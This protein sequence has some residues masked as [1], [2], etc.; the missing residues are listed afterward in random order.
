[1]RGL[2][3][4]RECKG[5]S[6]V[7][8][9]CGFQFL[10]L[11]TIISL[12][13][14]TA[15]FS[16]AKKGTVDFNIPSLDL[17]QA[18]N[19]FARQAKVE[20]V[21]AER[22][23]DGVRTR[24]VVGAFQRERALELLLAGTGLRVGF[25]SGDS[26]IVQRADASETPEVTTGLAVGAFDSGTMLLAQAAVDTSEGSDGLA[27]NVG[28]TRHS[29]D[30]AT[31]GQ[32]D[33][34]FDEIVITGTSIRG[35]VP[36]S[37]P[38]EI[39]DINAIRN[40]GAGTA[41]EFISTL[42]Q[43]S[44]TLTVVG[45]AGASDD[46]K[47]VRQDNAADLRGLGVGTTLVLLNGR[48]MAPSAGGRTAD[49]SFI[50]LGAVERVEVLTDGASAVYGADAVGGV[51]NFVL[52]DQQ[53]GAETS[54]GVGAVDGGRETLNVDQSFGFNW[55]DGNAFLTLG[56]MDQNSLSASDRSYSKA[57]APRILTGEERRTNVLG[58]IAQHLGGDISISGDL[59]HSTRAIA[60]SGLT[61]TPGQF[62]E[63]DIDKTQTVL[64]IAIE[65][66]LGETLHAELLITRAEYALDM[67]SYS[68]GPGTL[69]GPGFAEEDTSFLDVTAKLDG[70][71]TRL[72]SGAV[73]FSLGAGYSDEDIDLFD[74]DS[75]RVP[76]QIAGS[77][78]RSR[79]TKYAFAE[80][81]VPLISPEKNIPGI[82]RLEV[83]L[84]A[85]YTDYSDF[86][87][88]TDPKI[89][90]LWSPVEA[91]KVRGTFSESF[92]APPLLRL[93]ATGS[94]V[95]TFQPAT[96]GLPDIWSSDGSSIV[97]F[98]SGGSPSIGPEEARTY[99]FGFD[100]DLSGLSVSAT[101]FNI[102]Y[103]GRIAQ[104]DP[105]GGFAVA[106]SNPQ[107]FPSFFDVS[108]TVEQI[109]ALLTEVED[110]GDFI[111]C[112]CL[113]DPTTVD[114]ADI[115]AITTVAFDNR[116][117]N[118][119]VSETDGLDLTINYT[120]E[121]LG[122]DLSF[123]VHASKTFA[124]EQQA[125]PGD[126]PISVLDTVFFPA[127]FKARTYVG[128]QRERWHTRLSVN[129]VD[130]YGNPFDVANPTIDSWATADLM[131][132]YVVPTEGSG[133]WHGARFSL[134]IQNI[135]DEDPPF[136]PVSQVF[137][138]SIMF[139]IGFDP[140]NANPFGRIVNFRISKRW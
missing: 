42:T 137:G 106:L 40:T 77:V 21:F 71:L 125:F 6:P 48:R 87:E 10:V 117:Q 23:F 94:S 130:D 38:L 25:G 18:L 122:G 50:P 11:T 8:R 88:S 44:N 136:L 128:L 83:N 118:L 72:R 131:L 139:P 17:P 59:L 98:S 60:T 52:K 107:N 78:G 121:A 27:L 3:A 86:G 123:G 126:E 65:R 31:Q 82:R 138:R 61:L 81:Y 119:A 9:V 116:F 97:L 84:A 41:E 22:G 46:E 133:L 5:V 113:S 74:D 100:F 68:I 47:N 93:L 95:L 32:S 57:A 108:P 20:L 35:V 90:V 29:G 129:Y 34:A 30:E 115:L 33:A 49:L 16:Q 105:S 67:L 63:R 112:F 36:E 85:R 110:Y 101:Y 26:V 14:S 103:T 13:F 45:G 66:P 104:P 7:W 80:L 51:I 109:A 79:D 15:A 2:D 135:L 64:N 114:P 4:L 12:L 54:I 62:A 99:T 134:S 43:N 124:Y 120:T 37:S 140:A 132:S 24:A 69:P 1:M 102:D 111:G 55:A 91:L 56:Y 39:Y 19:E 127:D 92:R 89:G 75:L 53:E 96:F 58:T 76:G 70:E 28:A 73:R